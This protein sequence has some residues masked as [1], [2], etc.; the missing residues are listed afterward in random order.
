MSK[1]L[2][3]SFALLFLSGLLVGNTENKILTEDILNFEQVDIVDTGSS[4]DIF[5]YE[6]TKVAKDKKTYESSLFL[7]NYITGEGFKI[8]DKRTSYSNVQLGQNGKHIF[9]IDDGAGALRKTKQIWRKSIPYGIRKQLTKYNGDIRNFDL[10]PDETKIIFVGTAKKE[11]DS[12]KPIEIDRYQFKQDRQGF[13]RDVSNHLFLFDLKTKKLESFANENRNYQSPTWSPSGEFIAYVSKKED[14]DR[15]NNSDLFLKRYD[16]LENE[17]QLTFNMGSDSAGWSSNSLQWSADSKKIAYV[18][19]GDPKLL[20]YA[21]DNVSVIDIENKRVE[22]IT[23]A[24]DR[25][26]G[27]PRWSHDAARLYFVLEDNL[28]NQIAYYSFEDEKIRKMSPDE[29]YISSFEISGKDIILESSTTSEP[30][31]IFTMNDS[32]LRKVVDVNSFLSTKKIATTEKISFESYDGTEIF[33]LLVKPEDFNPNKK[34]PLLIRI[35]GGPVSQYGVR[36]NLEWQVFASNGYVVLAVNPRGSSGRGEEFQKAIFADWGN[37][38]AKDIIAAADFISTKSYIDAENLGIGGWSYGSMLTN[39]VI[40][41]DVRFQAA[42]SG[43]GISNILSGF[44][45]DHYIREYIDELGTPW[46]NLDVWMRISYPFFEADSIITP[47]LF[48]VGEKDFNVPLIGSEQMYQALRHNNIDTKLIIYP[49][50]NHGL[51]SPTNRIHRM[52]S[53]LEWYARYMKN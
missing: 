45:D 32:N 25:N 18:A 16:N 44:G 35:H 20:W 43:A 53:Y 10:S 4:G 15:H 29:M 3:L 24:L 6:K 47:T 19:G 27:S 36:F 17:V 12:L 31:S 41:S 33:G 11:T 14:S 21:I 26:T 49:G 9:Y 2:N 46:E 28:K 8:F 5:L 50:E 30:K 40:A 22:N 52:N 34:Y 38:D 51:S 37:I 39:Y 13:L 23:K 1:F 7:K 48:L 42:T